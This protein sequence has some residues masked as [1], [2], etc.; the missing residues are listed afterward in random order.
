ML[1][2]KLLVLLAFSPL[3]VMAQNT[4]LMLQGNAGKFYL[5]HTVGSKEN[6]YSVGRM[7]N[8]S[9]SVDL[10]PFNNLKMNEGLRIGQKIKIPLVEANFSR[11]AASGANEV[12]VPLHINAAANENIQ[13]IA[14]EYNLTE[15]Q[16]IRW[17]RMSGKKIPVSGKLIVGFLKVKKDLSTLAAAA[18]SMPEEKK[19]TAETVKESLNDKRAEKIDDLPVVKKEVKKEIKK[20]EVKTIPLEAETNEQKAAIKKET[21]R[22]VPVNTKETSTAYV[23]TASGGYFRSM[24]EGQTKNK[25][26]EEQSGSASLFKSSSGWS[27]GKYYCL[28]NGAAAGTVLKITNK[29]NNHTVY[30]K[31][32]DA[33]PDMKQNATYILL[34]SNAAASE[35]GTTETSFSCSVNY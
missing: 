25:S 15:A 11:D 14:D 18:F 10:A 28:F 9:P 34:L 7:Y 20:E 26:T 5:N 31:V 16:I 33:I 3:L 21:A 30:A 23:K 22:D 12:L 13:N 29:D 4:P 6:Y 19:I 17:N 24:Y 1:L 35:L 8:I 32:L 2:K 27:D